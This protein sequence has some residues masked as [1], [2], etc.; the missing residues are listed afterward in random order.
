M[1][2]P[3]PEGA[4]PTSFLEL[5]A[6]HARIY[7]QF[8]DHQEA[9]VARDFGRALE[10]LVA[11]RAAFEE[12]VRGEEELLHELF[13]RTDEVRGTPLDLFTSEHRHLREGLARFEAATRRLDPA[14]PAAAR[15]VIELLDDEALFKAFFRHHDERE[16]NLLYPAFDRSVPAPE[17]RERLQRFHQGL[18]PRK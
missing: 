3:R 13:A 16:R 5:L 10:R 7:E 9:L 2:D 11:V 12:H 18:P 15:H 8:V 1:T 14:S 4:E 17:R 6:V